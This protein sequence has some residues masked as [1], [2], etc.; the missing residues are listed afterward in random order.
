MRSVS[1][2]VILA[3]VALA[4]LGFLLKGYFDRN[5][6]AGALKDEIAVNNAQMLKLSD[7]NRGLESQINDYAN[8]Q[9]DMEQTIKAAGENIPEKM[10]S[11]SILHK[12]FDLCAR[13]HVTAIPLSTSDWASIQIKERSYSVFKISLNLKGTQTDLIDC[14][15][16]MQTEIYPTLVVENAVLSQESVEV[17]GVPSE[18][19]PTPT[20]TKILVPSVSINLAI[21]A[22]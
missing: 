1:I 19:T 5:T 14:V 11:N 9:A 4:V 20:S 2:V 3:L 8:Q 10:S 12:I 21:Y 6:A 7:Q 22:R 17:P 16:A 13:Y 15:R 18:N